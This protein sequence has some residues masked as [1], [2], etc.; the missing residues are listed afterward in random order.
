MNPQ[1]DIVVYIDC[2]YLN[3]Q[4]FQMLT[5]LPE[6]LQDSGEIGEFEL[7]VFTVKVKNLNT[8]EKELIVCEK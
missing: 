8:Y 2:Q 5:Q 1:N 3:H 4:N 6:I 7:D